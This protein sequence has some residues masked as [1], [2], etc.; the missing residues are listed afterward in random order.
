MEGSPRRVFLSHTSE[1]RDFP[2][3]GS[4]VAAAEAAVKRA[5]DAVT[6]MAYFAARDEMP[7][8][9]CMTTARGCDIYV[10]LIGLRYGSP[11]RDRQDVSYT[12]LEFD[13]ATEAGKTRLVFMLNEKTALPIP[14]DR[15]HDD[16]PD[17]RTRQQ[18]FRKR[19]SEAGLIVRTVA[20]PQQLETELYQA[21]METREKAP[22]QAEDSDT[23]ETWELRG[24]RPDPYFA[25]RQDELKSLHR[26]FRAKGS[27][28]AVQVISGLGGLGKTRLAIEYAWRYAA[29]YDLVWWIR[30]E[31]PATMRGDYAE[32]AGELGLP[33]EKDDQ[34]I[35]ALRQE[36]RRRRDWLL[37]FDNAEDPG[38]LFSLLPDRHQGHVLITSRRR[39]WQ[40][41][42]DR[43]LDVLSTEA[44]VGY[45]QQRGQVADAATARDLAE[46]LG[47]LP[48]ALAQAASVVAAGMAATD[49][50]ALLRQQS[51]ELFTEGH[52]ADHDMTI[53]STWRVSVD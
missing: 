14:A 2:S 8:D 45:L 16:D 23:A 13:T 39:E 36:L 3:D 34:A 15:L 44:A 42:E 11:V 10:G 47:C 38:E 32:L 27:T 43:R 41:T 22:S 33:S 28:S 20:T 12:E 1:L 49:Y 9:Y 46:A 17:L 21:L 53:G 35:A 30:A 29:D 31:D 26:A 40:H 51:P 6:E 37:I 50:L 7:A 4:F 52:P 18:T 19:L 48:L 24:H 25:G 5:G